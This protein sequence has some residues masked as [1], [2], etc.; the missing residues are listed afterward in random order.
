MPDRNEVRI[1]IDRIAYRSPNQ[2][3]GAALY[4]MVWGYSPAQLRQGA[5]RELVDA[6]ANDALDYRVLSFETLRELTGATHGYRPDDQEVKRRAAV[7]TWKK[8][9][10]RIAP[11]ADRAG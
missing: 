6:L 11:R 8:Q 9:I 1:H 2:T 7:N 3:D 4:R 10:G 5:D